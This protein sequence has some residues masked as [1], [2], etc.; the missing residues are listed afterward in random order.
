MTDYDTSSAFDRVL[1]SLSIITCQRVGLPC[2]AGTFMFYLLRYMSFHLVTGFGKS[3]SSFENKE[4]IDKVGQGVLQ[5]SSSAAPIYI[6]NSDVSHSTYNHLSKGAAFTHPI[7]GD[8]IVDKTIQYV[9]DT[10]QILNPKGADLESTISH[11][12]CDFYNRLNIISHSGMIS[13]RFLA[14]IYILINVSI[15]HFNL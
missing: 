13:C 12:M 15:T 9:D 6:L 7:S 8:L 1:A 2:N 14:E 4:D 5:G 3:A 10:S 11:S